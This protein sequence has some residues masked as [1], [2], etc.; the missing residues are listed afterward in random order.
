MEGKSY[1]I[2]AINPGSTSTKAAVFKNEENIATSVIRH[3]PEDFAGCRSLNDQRPIRMKSILDMLSGN[4]IELSQLDA[5]VGRG[6]LLRP[7]PSGVYLVGENMLSDLSTGFASNH[8][9]SLGGLLAREIGD[10][11]S[12]PAYIADPIV[13]DEMDPIARISGIPQIERRSI[14]HA[15]NA[16]AVARKSASDMGM[17]YEDARLIVAHMGG[18]ISVSAH[19]NG[20]VIDVNDGLYGEG[21]FTPERC[22]SL[23]FEQVV[24]LCFSGEYTM[25]EMIGFAVRRGGMLA[26]IGTNDLREAEE[27]IGNGDEKAREIVEAMA[28]QVSKEIG[29]AGAVLKFDVDLIILTGGLA[30]ST[31]FTGLISERVGRIARVKLYPG[32]EELLS[33]AQG[34]LRVLRGEE[35]ASVY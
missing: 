29:S 15:L 18:G 16:K 6:G 35:A 4:N 21:P 8:P 11:V 19:R 30:Y 12:I 10:K 25:D 32:E 33:L 5:V 7:I 26:Y 3:A 24:R 2:L 14:F 34:A 9:S 13:V 28:Y 27:R 22:G 17:K 1:L 23:P 31:L 20:R